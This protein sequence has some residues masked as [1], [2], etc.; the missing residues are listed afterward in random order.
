MGRC[1]VADATLRGAGWLRYWTATE[2]VRLVSVA[3]QD[4]TQPAPRS[5]VYATR[6]LTTG[7]H[8][9]LAVDGA[10][11]DNA[12]AET[13]TSGSAAERP[14]DVSAP[15]FGVLVAVVTLVTAVVIA[16]FRPGR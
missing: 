15:G 9:A 4:L 2:A 11:A 6:N 1:R 5:V 8:P 7:F 14:T 10:V 12:T 3:V 16:R 13:T